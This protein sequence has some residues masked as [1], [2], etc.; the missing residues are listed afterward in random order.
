MVAGTDATTVGMGTLVA[1]AG[2]QRMNTI[3]KLTRRAPKPSPPII[4]VRMAT[5]FG[6]VPP[7]DPGRSN[8]AEEDESA[9]TKP[10]LR[11]GRPSSKPA[12]TLRTNHRA[13]T[14]YRCG[15]IEEI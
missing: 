6:Q 11:I 10:R 13:F 2:A 12:G 8:F 9:V 3:A 14:G 15:G 5:P 7:P 4:T 1:V